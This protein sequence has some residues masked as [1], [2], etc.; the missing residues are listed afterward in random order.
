M[1]LSLKSRCYDKPIEDG[2]TQ[3][4]VALASQY[5]GYGYRRVTA[6]L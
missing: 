4:I 3:V 2:L 5:G 6:L 1:R